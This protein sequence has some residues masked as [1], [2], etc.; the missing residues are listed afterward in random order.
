[1]NT[2][3]EP[4]ITP[5]AAPTDAERMAIIGPLAAFSLERGYRFEVDPVVL[6]LR[7]NG[8]IVGGLI[9]H[10]N[11][12]WLYVEILSVAE[13]LRGQGH[14][15]RLMAKAETIARGRGCVGAWVDTYSFQSPGFYPAVGYTLFGELPHCP[16]KERRLFFRKMLG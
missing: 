15:R 10:T 6:V 14:G 2:S 16:G 7:A 12:G 5:L 4:A 11:F 3:T 9:G 13:T 1:M 8:E